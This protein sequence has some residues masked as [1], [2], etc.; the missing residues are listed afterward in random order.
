MHIAARQGD[1]KLMKTYVEQGAE[2]ETK[3]G[4][5]VILYTECK[6]VDFVA[7]L[8]SHHKSFGVRQGEPGKII[9]LI[10]S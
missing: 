3:N 1:L 9:D 8:F 5:G 10:L 2:L 6:I 4:T 7:L